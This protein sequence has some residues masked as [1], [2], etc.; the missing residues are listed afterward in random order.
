MTSFREALLEDIREE[1]RRLR[2]AGDDHFYGSW[3]GGSKSGGGRPG[4]GGGGAADPNA[5][6]QQREMVAGGERKVATLRRAMNA[7]GADKTALSGALR[8]QQDKLD[9]DRAA[10]AKMEGK[11]S[12]SMGKDTFSADRPP[13][14]I[15]KAEYM[16]PDF[17]VVAGDRI[18]GAKQ[19]LTATQARLDNEGRVKAK[20]GREAA[21]QAVNQRLAMDADRARLRAIADERKALQAKAP[22]PRDY[23]R[24]AE[25]E[26][27]KSAY[28]SKLTALKT[29]E[30]GINDKYRRRR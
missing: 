25:Y 22:N 27:A 7:P 8:T 9:R 17:K 20:A 10:L 2:E 11:G 4:G 15:T 18:A 30:T 6:N 23:E 24:A 1:A 12:V 26:K 21:R 14:E 28:E 16:N 5:L 29:E 19:P 13:R 3:T